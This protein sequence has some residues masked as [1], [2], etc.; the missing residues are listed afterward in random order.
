V[1]GEAEQ[2]W[3]RAIESGLAGKGFMPGKV[4]EVPGAGGA[5]HSQGPAFLFRGRE[6]AEEV[7]RVA[8]G[9][10]HSVNLTAF[11]ILFPFLILLLIYF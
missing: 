11:V 7:L 6:A 10:G 5:G 8:M 9:I 3:R 2:D 1:Q 4:R